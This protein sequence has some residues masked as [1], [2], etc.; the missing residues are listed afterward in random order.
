MSKESNN[1]NTIVESYNADLV[2]EASE[3]LIGELSV[4]DIGKIQPS[5]GCVAMFKAAS[6]SG[7]N[8]HDLAQV[9]QVAQLQK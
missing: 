8:L 5:I 7:L 2:D 6:S 9:K 4:T 1:N 3:K